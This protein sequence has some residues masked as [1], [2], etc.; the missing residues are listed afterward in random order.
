V[1]ADVWKTTPF[2]A[3]LVLAG[4]QSIDPRLYDAARTDGA[5]SWQQFVHVT[6]PMLRP[7]LLV[8][9]VFRSLD[10]FRVF[11]LVYGL[12][13]G[14]PGTATESISMLAFDTLLRDLR[15]GRGAAISLVL[16]GIT[17]GVAVVYARLLRDD[18]EHR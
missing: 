4:L 17:A 2:V 18:E 6:L 9:L 5:S 3:I 13:G 8:I 16:F 14:G 7:T 11:D 10:A 15:F 12:T 1:L